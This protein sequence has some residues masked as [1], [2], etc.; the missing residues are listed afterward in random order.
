VRSGAA[1][2][3]D[4]RQT[5]MISALEAS[6]SSAGLFEVQTV[7]GEVVSGMAGCGEAWQGITGYGAPLRRGLLLSRARL[8][9]LVGVFR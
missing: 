7:Q 5:L 1:E 3:G 6:A 9:L 8:L 2:L 4:L